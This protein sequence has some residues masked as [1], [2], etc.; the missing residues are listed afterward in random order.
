ME[1]RAAEEG[2]EGGGGE[3]V[4]VGDVNDPVGDVDVGKTRGGDDASRT[5]EQALASS[6]YETR[7]SGVN[8]ASFHGG[9]PGTE[10]EREAS[11]ED[12]GMNDGGC[13]P[14]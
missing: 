8:A 9:G 14:G 2:E 5:I 6:S 4:V 3:D 13:K 1:S 11:R 7:W 12:D 10:V